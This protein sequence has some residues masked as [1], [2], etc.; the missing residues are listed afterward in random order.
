MDCPSDDVVARY[1]SGALEERQIVPF[2]SHL[3]RCDDCRALVAEAGRDGPT[4]MTSD[5]EL[6]ELWSAPAVCVKVGDTLDGKYRLESILGVGGMG[7]VLRGTHV[8]LGLA[9][10]IKIMHPEL[11]AALE[12]PRRFAQEGRAAAALTSLHA[13]RIL[14]ID[15]LPSGVPYIVMEYLEG[16]DLHRVL[17]DEGPLPVA[18]VI[19][20][21]L[22][23]LEAVGEAHGRGVIHRDLKPQNLFLTRGHII[24]VLDF[25]LAKALPG[26]AARHAL[27]VE[28]KTAALMGTPHYMAPEQVRPAGQVNARTDVYGLGATMYELLT[29]VPPFVAQNIFALFAKILNDEPTCVGALRHDVPLGLEQVIVRC[30]AKRPEERYASAEALGKALSEHRADFAGRPAVARSAVDRPIDVSASLS[31]THRT[32]PAPITLALEEPA[33]RQT[34]LV[35]PASAAAS[36]VGGSQQGTGPPPP[37]MRVAN[38]NMLPAVDGPTATAATADPVAR[39]MMMQA[40]AARVGLPRQPD[41]KPRRSVWIAMAVGVV[42]LSAAIVVLAYWMLR[43]SHVHP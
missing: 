41:A 9:V 38:S 32:G 18:R 42:A 7:T 33:I 30:L 40:S 27:A 20:Y 37:P 25:G 34:T 15:R 10:A 3:D 26:S 4:S 13:A 16:R 17:R 35:M 28:T 11:L 31:S 19:D 23:A 24:K 8:E 39:G 1:L 36:R 22:Q 5:A 43:I 29:G 14:D 6:T 21:I 12:A 2:R